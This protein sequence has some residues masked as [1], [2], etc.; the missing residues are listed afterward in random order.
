[1]MT[2]DLAC[3]SKIGQN[4]LAA[5]PDMRHRP[6]SMICAYL[7]HEKHDPE[8]FWRPYIDVLRLPSEFDKI[9]V[10][11][12]TR[13]LSLLKGSLAVEMIE[14]R[15][16]DYKSRHQKFTKHVSMCSHFTFEE[17]CWAEVMVITR[18]FSVGNEGSGMVPLVDTINHGPGTFSWGDDSLDGSFRVRPRRDV[19]MG[20]PV[21]ISFGD[22]GNHRW[23]V[24]YGMTFEGNEAFN[25]AQVDIRDLFKE[26]KEWK[27]SACTY[28]NNEIYE[29]C[30]MCGT[31]RY[32]DPSDGRERREVTHRSYIIARRSNVQRNR[33]S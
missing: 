23:F 16:R 26:Q 28:L 27:C 13:M 22:K 3:A 11:F 5:L 20:T 17:W 29:S 24:N 32:G 21:S 30:E 15:L 8:S 4:V 14:E 2:D 12:S 18:V 7:L 33:V 10:F 31:T 25:V 1:M 9:P 6:H 19:K